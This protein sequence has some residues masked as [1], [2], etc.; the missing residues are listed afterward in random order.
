MTAFK[1]VRH[2]LPLAPTDDRGPWQVE[3]TVTVRGD[4]QRGSVRAMLPSTEEGQ[5]IFDERAS[6]DRLDWEIQNR[7]QGRIGLWSGRLEG[8]HEVVYRFRVQSSR[9]V[10]PM[11]S[12]VEL[13]E[14]SAAD[15]ALYLKPSAS[16]PSTAPAVLATIE[17]FS[18]PPG[19]D[20]AGRIQTIF[21]FVAHEISTV[22]SAANDLLLTLDRREGSAEGKELLLVGLL[23]AADIPARLVHGLELAEGARPVARV[24]AEAW[25]DGAWLPLSAVEGFIGIRPVDWVVVG[26]GTLPPVEASGARAVGH[27]YRAL[28]EHLRPD[29]IASLMAP[30]DP[31]LSFLSL[32]RLPVGAQS[33]L[34]LLLLLPL[35]ALVT[36]LFRNVIGVNTYGTFMPALVGLALR[37]LPPALGLALVGGVLAIGVSTRFALERLRLLMVPRLS[38]L[39][40]VVVLC[41]MAVALLSDSIG[42]RDWLGG[43]A[44]PIVILTMWIERITITIEEEGR[45]EAAR[46]ALWSLLVALAILPIYQSIYASYLMFTFP[47]LVISVVGLL[48]WIGGYTGFRLME[49][50]R[51]RDFGTEEATP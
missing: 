40:C 3:L 5:R 38:V 10:V 46:R 24:W 50:W 51:F 12:G 14:A 47:E 27:R 48:V 8:V 20:P 2:E 44:L 15:R 31:V 6:S 35:G 41:V 39:L 29:E 33:L 1:V 36:A 11:T 23:R 26:R 16:I 45:R 37:D 32:Y 4:G 22:P 25:L 17:A 28:R 30:D 43:A 49:L 13:I 18:L 9:V 34:R 7:E 19:T 42:A 21:A